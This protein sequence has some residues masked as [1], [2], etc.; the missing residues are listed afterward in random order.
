MPGEDHVRNS[1]EKHNEVRSLKVLLVLTAT[2]AAG[3]GVC[4]AFDP[5]RTNE[6]EVF[7]LNLRPLA[8]GGGEGEGE[9]G[10]GDGGQQGEGGITQGSLGG[11]DYLCD[12]DDFCVFKGYRKKFLGSGCKYDPKQLCVVQKNELKLPGFSI[13]L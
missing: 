4:M 10:Q 3:V 12:E 7:D 8:G 9:G 13:S 11:V 2:L 5:Y 6:D 1:I